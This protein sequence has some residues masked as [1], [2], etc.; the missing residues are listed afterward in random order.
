M[1]TQNA[2]RRRTGYEQWQDGIDAADDRW[3]VYDDIIR[4][5]VDQYNVHLARTTPHSFALD[6]KLV[7]AMVWTETGADSRKWAVRPMQIGNPG[8]PG[9]G[10]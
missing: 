6:W 5:T 9:L 2:V 1:A 3:D 7:K 10:A 8:D 4:S